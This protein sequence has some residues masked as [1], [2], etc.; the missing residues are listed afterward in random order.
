[1]PD[2]EVE[3]NKRIVRCYDDD[4]LAG[5]NLAALEDLF[6][7]DFV[8]HSAGYGDFTLVDVRATIAQ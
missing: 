5:R 2:S 6:V 8:G 1:M 7:P 3:A 4:V